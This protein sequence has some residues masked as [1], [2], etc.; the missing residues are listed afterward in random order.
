MALKIF[1]FLIL[2][3]STKVLAISDD[4]KAVFEWPGEYQAAVSLSYDDGLNSQLTYAVP[5]LDKYGFKASFY[6]TLSNPN[7]TQNLQQWRKVAAN[8]HELGNHTLYHPCR[9]SIAGR[10]WVIS[11]QDLDTQVVEQIR[12]EVILANTL[13]YAIDNKIER[14]FTP[15][16]GDFNVSDG[17]YI[18]AIRDS[19]IAI[20][21]YNPQ[22]S[23]KFDQLLMPENVSGETL[24]A[25]V[26]KVK[27]EGG[28]AN[29]VFHGIEGDYLT[30]S[31]KAHNELLQ[32]LEENKDTLWVDTYSTIMKYV[33]TEHH[34]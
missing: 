13:L 31:D 4:K 2:I 19:F 16:C 33:K 6:L 8:G 30:V 7:L 26:N 12:Q 20:K 11:Y 5:A 17:N 14:T 18:A 23:T 21:G 34:L 27:S 32:Y 29:I 10:D 24:I 1:V 22:Y 15:P 25:F 3:V 9:K 28:I